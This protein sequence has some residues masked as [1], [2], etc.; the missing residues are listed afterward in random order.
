MKITLDEFITVVRKNASD[1][2][3]LK[4]IKLDDHLGDIGIDSLGFVTLLWDVED[5]FKISVDDQCLEHLNYASTVSDLI[6]TFGE[7]G[8]TITT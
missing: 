7:N 2:V 5:T 1:D 4:E 6:S 8:L 3:V